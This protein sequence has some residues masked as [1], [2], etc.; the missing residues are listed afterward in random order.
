MQAA[1]SPSPLS[2]LVHVLTTCIQPTPGAWAQRRRT[3][4]SR[5][6][7]SPGRSSWRQ[8]RARA[9]G[10][11]SPCRGARPR[12]RRARRVQARPWPRTAAPAPAR[13]RAGPSAP[14]GSSSWSRLRAR[15]RSRRNRAP[16]PRASARVPCDTTQR[17]GS[18]ST[19]RP[20]HRHT[21]E[22]RSDRRRQTKKQSGSEKPQR[23]SAAASSRAQRR[24]HCVLEASPTH[25]FARPIS[26]EHE[27]LIGDLER[28]ALFGLGALLQ[29][30]PANGQ[31]QQHRH[32]QSCAQIVSL[33]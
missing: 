13:D 25:R 3:A 27:L 11:G 30:L 7:Q 14:R 33:D 15:G 8:G 23:G 9:P 21:D 24:H 6:V 28:A 26:L 2:R 29:L 4:P 19:C 31:T 32:T 20:S 10:A 18:R 5:R 16:R 17:T 1:P 22:H 12:R